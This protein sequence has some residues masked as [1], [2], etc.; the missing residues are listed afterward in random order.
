MCIVG[1]TYTASEL[2]KTCPLASC[3]PGPMRASTPL[4]WLR[5]QTPVQ[6]VEWLWQGGVEGAANS[7]Q[8]A[9]TREPGLF[10]SHLCADWLAAWCT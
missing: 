3:H 4:A 5:A 1:C 7:T 9:L 6:G 8:H 2:G 10:V